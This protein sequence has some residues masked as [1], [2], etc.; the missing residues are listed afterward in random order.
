MTPTTSILRGGIIFNEI[1]V[2]P[3][4][5][6]YDFDTDGNGSIQAREE[7]IE[8]YNSATTA[9]DIGGLQLWDA[10][11]RNWFTFPDATLLA[12]RSY[13]Y[14]VAG[15]DTAGGALPM[16]NP[17]TL[18]FSAGRSGA[19]IN[20]AG[21]NVV[22]FD[23]DADEFI[24]LSFDDDAEDDPTTYTGFSATAT[25]IGSTEDFGATTPGIA[26][27]RNLFSSTEILSQ[28]DIL[29]ATLGEPTGTPGAANS[30][31]SHGVD[32]IIGTA[33]DNI[34]TAGD[35]D[36][37]VSGA[38][39]N[40]LLQGHLGDDTLNGGD[41]A[42]RLFGGRGNDVLNGDSGNDVLH[43]Q[44]GTDTLNGGAGNDRLL[45]SSGADTLNGGSGNDVLNGGSGN[46]SLMGG[47]GIDRLLGLSGDDTLS[48]GGLA[49]GERDFLIGGNG[50]DTFVLGTSLEGVLYAGGQGRRGS[51]DRAIIQDFDLTEGD[52]IQLVGSGEDYRIE[53]FAMGAKSRLLLE[54]GA[55]DE[56]IA[57]FTGDIVAGGAD[58]ASGSGFSFVTV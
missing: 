53:T 50:A 5:S 51:L 30:S 58:L 3:N 45:G 8:L 16:P 47:A 6:T 9:V 2:N 49:V 4:G 10:G 25:R 22:L 7:Y 48:G 19:V 29:D 23:P 20:N 55:V 15:Y 1:L 34:L 52:V 31:G 42:D 11:S 43:G 41:G 13:A 21:D 32:T 12:A 44:P 56:I 37:T 26:A 24:Q 28:T 35:S 40:D 38:G 39:G 36:D 27:V 46:D 54:Q 57:T 17:D 33:L 18:A 14:V